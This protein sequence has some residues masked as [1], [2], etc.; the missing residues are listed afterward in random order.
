MNNQLKPASILGILLAVGLISIGILLGNSIVKFKK[1]DRSVRVKGLAEKEVKANKAI[2]PI[3]FYNVSNSIDDLYKQIDVS[4]DKLLVYLKA[5]DFKDNE[6]TKGVPNITDNYSYNY[7]DKKKSEYRY[8]SKR[9]VTIYT[10]SVD[11]VLKTKEDIIN[12]GK[13]GIIVQGYD[14]YSNRTEFIYTGLNQIKPEMIEL[15]TKNAREVALK[16]AK[17]SKSRLGKIKSA[18]QGQFTIY[19]RDSNTPHIKK[20]RVVSTLNYYLID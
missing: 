8:R 1:L 19:N 2:W 13:R 6:I 12:L 15:A 5:R 9:T 17:D 10:D 20:V 3:T 11:S 16:F 7:N 4:T 14:D 18:N